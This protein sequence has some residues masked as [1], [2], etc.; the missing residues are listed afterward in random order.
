MSQ[1]LI[2]GPI[3]GVLLLNEPMSRHVSWR[4]GGP[5]LRYFEPAD[6]DDL[7]SFL[8]SRVDPEEPL[9]WIGLGSN[10]LVRDGGL[11][12]TVIATRQLNGLE[13]LDDCLVRVEAGV[14]C[15]KLARFCA[16]E[17][18]AGAEFLVGIPGTMG[19]A[20]AM[21]AGCFGG[22]T[23]RLVE[24][25]ETIDRYGVRRVRQPEVYRVGYRSVEGPSEEWFVGATL[26]LHSGDGRQ[27]AERM[28]EMLEQRG[29]T[30]PTQQANA[31]SVFRN[32]EGDYAARLIESCGLKGV[33]IGQ[34]QVSQK[35]ANFIVNVG[36]AT[37]G[38]IEA[39]IERVA[40]QVAKT[41]G[42]LLQREVRIIGERAETR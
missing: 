9:Y 36:G 23:W 3:R 2:Q 42:I 14:P 13:K 40:E 5:A 31:G 27:L 21:N 22:E 4:A 10:L 24:S 17:G 35:H 34:A 20:L 8:S 32:P 11:R 39:L 38:D 19:G 7:V 28:R 18:L 37:A 30:Q 41:H 26:R 1:P 29:T 15:A 16:R 33:C 12:A 25:V 6:L